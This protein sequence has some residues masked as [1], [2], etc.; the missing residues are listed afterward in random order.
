MLPRIQLVI[1]R[2][3]TCERVQRCLLDVACVLIVAD[4]SAVFWDAV[5]EPAD[6]LLISRNRIPEPAA[7]T[8]ESIAELPSFPETVVLIDTE[9]ANDRAELLAAGAYALLSTTISDDIFRETILA[10]VERRQ[11][12]LDSQV[13]SDMRDA[14]ETRLSDFASESPAMQRFMRT[15]RR[16][17]QADS[18]L[19]ILGETGV[20]KERLA[21][22]I[23][24]ASPRGER[25]FVPVNCAAFPESLLESELFGHEEGAFTGASSDRRGCFEMAHGGTIF[26]DEIGE[27]PKYVQVKL[28][29]VLQERQIQRLG[30]EESIPIDVRIMAATNRDLTEEMEARRFRRD[31]YYRLSVVTLAIPSLR[32]HPEDIPSLLDRYLNEFRTT[33][34]KPDLSYSPLAITALCQYAWPGNVRELINVVERAALLCEGDEI[35]LADLPPEI[36]GASR[37]QPYAPPAIESGDAIP[38]PSEWQSLHWS[39]LRPLVARQLEYAYLDHHLKA[40]GGRISQTAKTSGLS[41]RSLY[42]MMKRHGL[43]KETFRR[44]P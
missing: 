3:S 10:L 29:R 11:A 20:G 24:E 32:E 17:V 42:L 19:L 18:S 43:R 28:L 2:E 23:H 41:T 16:V 22:A 21:R 33:V 5:G 1:D 39:T 44:K 15:V 31:L 27:V 40:A 26:L 9:D 8:I 6:L 14:T 30:S 35:T 38:L 4:Q 34:R 7:E 13:Q 36:G 25:P 12:E 37:D